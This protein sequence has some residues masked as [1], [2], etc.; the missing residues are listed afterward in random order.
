[1][2]LLALDASCNKTSSGGSAGQG[3]TTGGDSGQ[4]D[5]GAMAGGSPGSGGN[6]A[7]TGGAIGSGGTQAASSG[8]VTGSGGAAGSGGSHAGAGGSGSGGV[9]GGG[10][11]PGN[12][13][14]TSTP[15]AASDL[16]TRDTRRGADASTPQDAAVDAP[17]VLADS[18]SPTGDGGC[19]PN[20]SCKP[21][22]PN[23]GDPEAD[24]VA[25]VNQFRAC[26]CLPPLAR[27]TAG[28][29]CAN[30]DSQY[31]SQQNSAHAG[32]IAGICAS[33]NAQDECPD[34]GGYTDESV[35]DK[36]LQM[37]FDEGPPPTTSCT[38]TCYETHGH[39]INMTGTSYKNGVACG[40]YTT[41]SGSVW[42]AQ[43][44]Q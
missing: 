7:G 24:C 9:L 21:T 23:T 43:N 44:F 32:F 41:A 8:G 35:I 15:D 19:V 26:V 25:R 27:W 29:A 28:E 12:G 18:G 2:F 20:Y 5:G 33:G 37:M 36:C 42:A 10:G 17:A 40:F 30:Q 31:D 13:G 22:S 6:A 16:A 34:W 4:G 14:T 39:Y 3:G 11:V 38:G 1:V